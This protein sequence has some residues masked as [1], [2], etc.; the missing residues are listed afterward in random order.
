MS[1]DVEKCVDRKGEDLH[2][3][4]GGELGHQGGTQVIHRIHKPAT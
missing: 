2:V 3:V 1:Q 4:G